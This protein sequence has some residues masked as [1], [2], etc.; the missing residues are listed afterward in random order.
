VIIRGIERHGRVLK[1]WNEKVYSEYDMEMMK[2]EFR[3][4]ME[5][6]LE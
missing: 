1:F 3:N 6:V 5:S 2:K 4:K